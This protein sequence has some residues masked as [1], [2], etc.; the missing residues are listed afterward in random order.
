MN[1]LFMGLQSASLIFNILELSG[2]FFMSR[3]F[4][5]A[6]WRGVCRRKVVETLTDDENA[7]H[8]PDSRRYDGEK[9]P[10]KR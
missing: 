5:L 6:S 7:L 2:R 4:I 9:R 1:F 8:F 3:L 10:S